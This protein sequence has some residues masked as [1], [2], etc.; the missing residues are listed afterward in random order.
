MSKKCVPFE[1]HILIILFTPHHHPHNKPSHIPGIKRNNRP[2]K[3]HEII[4]FS[5]SRVIIQRWRLLRIPMEKCKST[6]FPLFT[7]DPVYCS[8][9]LAHF[10][11]GQLLCR[12]FFLEVKESFQGTRPRK[13]K[14]DGTMH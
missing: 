12:R 13:R 11:V 4:Q 10:F 2:G 5:H 14:R 7:A 8:H 9:A 6:Y 1:S 3:T